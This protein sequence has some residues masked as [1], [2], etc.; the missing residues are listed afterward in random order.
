MAE[1]K[2]QSFANH[3]RLDPPFHFFVLPVAGLTVI[4]SIVHAVQRP[5]WF[6][7]WLVIFALAFA[8]FVVRMRM[9]ALR[10][11]DC[12]IRFEERLRLGG[13]LAEPLCF[14]VGELTE[15]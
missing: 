15:R 11:Q 13:L 4:A 6:A 14:R 5:S 3:V 7:G 2:P 9:Y 12:S 8:V 10:M 1:R